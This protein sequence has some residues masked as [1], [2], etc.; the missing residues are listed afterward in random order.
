MDLKVEVRPAVSRDHDAVLNLASRLAIGVATW[1]DALA[2]AAAVRDW[3]ETSMKPGD[4]RAAFVAVSDEH[5]VGFVSV[6]STEHF[7]GERDAYIGELMVDEAVEGRGVGHRLVD[8][9]A[10]WA[11]QAGHRCITLHTGA[12]NGRARRFYARLGYGEEDIKL[13][14]VLNAD[15]AREKRQGGA[16]DGPAEYHEPPEAVR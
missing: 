1:R 9:A 11:H 12:A 10:R 14:K 2:V 7:A 16:S 6:V 13:T 8:A 15:V 4:G 5:V 3:L